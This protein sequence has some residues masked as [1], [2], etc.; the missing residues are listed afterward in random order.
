MRTYRT[1]ADIRTALEPHRGG[2]IGLVPTMGGAA[3]G[4]SLSSRS[5]ARGV[6]DRRDEPV[7]QPGAVRR[8]RRPERV[9]PRRGARPGRRS[10]SRRRP[11]LRSGGR[12]DVPARIPARGRG[13]KRARRCSRARTGRGTLPRRRDGVPQALHDRAPGRRLLRPEGRPAGRRPPAADRR[14]RARA[15]RAARPAHGEGHGRP[16]ALLPEPAALGRRAGASAGA[17]ARPRNPRPRERARA[18]RRPRGRLRRD[19]PVRTPRPRRRGPRRFHPPDRQ[20]APRGG[21]TSTRPR[22]PGHGAPAPGKL[23]IAEPR[24][25]EGEPL[26][27]RDD[28]RLRRP[29]RPAGRRGGRGRDPRRRLRRD[30]GT[31]ARL[32][33]PGDDGGD[34]GADP[35]R[36]ARRPAAAHH[37]RHAVWLVPG[38]GRAR[39]SRMRFASSRMRAP[40]PSRSRGPARCSRASARSSVPGSP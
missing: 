35:R 4:A 13:R 6:L 33:R 17:A 20:H 23:P 32:D 34:A 24:R 8:G 37:R 9:P 19:R 38:I 29:I 18:A 16:R 36:D 15:P 26:A 3:R 31:G 10:R 22:N 1:I 21:L 7:R 12:G 40:T 39:W 2:R 28:H 27:D 14:S 25:D 11:R 30:D 5:C